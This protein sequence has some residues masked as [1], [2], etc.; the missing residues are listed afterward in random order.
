[1]NQMPV[2]GES[3][4]ARVLAHGRNGNPVAKRHI[5]NGEWAEKTHYMVPLAIY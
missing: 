4:L 1:M 3:I 2:S 5:P